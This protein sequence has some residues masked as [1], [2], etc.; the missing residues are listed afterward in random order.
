VKDSAVMMELG[1]DGE[2]TFEN[3]VLEIWNSN[4]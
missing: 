4:F 1:K 3:V 2:L